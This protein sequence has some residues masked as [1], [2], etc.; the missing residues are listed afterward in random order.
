MAIK[1]QGTYLYTIDPDDESL[2]TVGCITSLD[3]V[4]TT[5]EQIETTCLSDLARTYISGLATP[6]TATFGINFDTFD[7]SHVRLH[8]LK[9]AGTTLLWAI[10]FSDDTAAATVDSAGTFDLATTRSWIRFNGFMNSYQFSF[11][12][13]SVVTSTVGIQ[14]SGEPEVVAKA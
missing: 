4:D 13:N 11:A 12:Q 8:Q 10:G 5:N 3:G 9:V 14:I 2:I 7:D 1:V 6:G